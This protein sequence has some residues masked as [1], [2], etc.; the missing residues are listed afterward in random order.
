MH[1]HLQGLTTKKQS[2]TYSLA[3]THTTG[4]HPPFDDTTEADEDKQET[5]VPH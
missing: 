4:I 3:L 5:V 1:M 2:Q